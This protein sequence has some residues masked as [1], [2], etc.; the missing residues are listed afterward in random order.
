VTRLPG[1]VSDEAFW[2]SIN[3]GR[4]DHA[5]VNAGVASAGPI[6]DLSLAEWRRVPSVNLDGTFLTLRSALGFIRD[7][8]S[9]VAVSSA[10]GIK[11]EP[12]IAAYGTSKA[13]LIQLARI[14]AKEG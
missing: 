11:A 3:L 10:A 6:V 12:G 9:I 2:Q 7:C 1:D 8:G 13:G 14:A 4:I 5:V